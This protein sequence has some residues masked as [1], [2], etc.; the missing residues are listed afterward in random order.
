MHATYANP[1]HADVLVTWD[2]DRAPMLVSADDPMLEGV[3]IVPYVP[4][5][6]GDAPG[7]RY[8]PVHVVRERLEGGGLWDDM[9]EAL[10]SRPAMMLKVLTLAEGIA[11]DDPDATELLTAIGADPAEILAP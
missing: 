5:Q 11:S 10:I 4:D 8:V 7:P 6:G 9:A 1:E 2:E 3:E